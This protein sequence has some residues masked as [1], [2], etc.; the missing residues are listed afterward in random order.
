MNVGIVRVVVD[1]RDGDG[2]DRRVADVDTLDILTA[3]AISGNIHLSWTEWK[4]RHIATT[5]AN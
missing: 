5:S 3:G 1:V 4:P 2:I